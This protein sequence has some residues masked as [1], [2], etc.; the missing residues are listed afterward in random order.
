MAVRSLTFARG[1][2][3]LGEG[4]KMFGRSDALG[5]GALNIVGGG[6]KPKKP[7]P[8]GRNTSL[9]HTI[10]L[11]CEMV[12]VGEDGKRSILARVSVVNE[13]GPGAHCPPRHTTH[14]AP[15]FIEVDGILRRG[16]QCLPG[17]VVPATSSTRTVNPRFLS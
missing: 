16:K 5:T 17:P 7:L 2:Q 4:S 9:T 3:A 8:T 13:V 1:H 14:H 15:S 11:D 6:E 12:G 10:A